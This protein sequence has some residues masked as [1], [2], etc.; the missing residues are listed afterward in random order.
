MATVRALCAQDDFDEVGEVYVESWKASYRDLLPQAFLEKL[1]HDRW[2]GML[3]ADPSASLAVFEEGRAVGTAM[4]GYARE[5]DREGFGEIISLYLRPEAMGRG[6]GRRLLEA[7]LERLHGDGCEGACLWVLAGNA[8]A[9]GFY[10]HM[11]F[12]ASGRSQTELF[13][14]M[15]A[16]LVEMVLRW[17]D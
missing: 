7:A 12:E 2:S 13:G 5:A 17:Q 6:Y 14:S 8:R 10:R 16:E 9:R 3:R 15:E 11:G 1:T 4:I